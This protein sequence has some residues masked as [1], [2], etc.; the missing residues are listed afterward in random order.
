MF[1]Q[2]SINEMSNLFSLNSRARCDWIG[3]D[4]NSFDCF[5]CDTIQCLPGV[6]YRQLDT[7]SMYGAKYLA[8]TSYIQGR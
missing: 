2:I 3:F 4:L 8:M 6:D 5:V 7:Y 1:I